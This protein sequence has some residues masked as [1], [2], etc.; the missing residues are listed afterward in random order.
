MKKLVIV[1]IFMFMIF[2]GNICFALTDADIS[3]EIKSSI[4]AIRSDIQYTVDQN[5]LT[6]AEGLKNKASSVIDYDVKIGLMEEINNLVNEIKDI[7][8]GTDLTKIAADIKMV[9]ED[10]D[11]KL[12]LPSTGGRYTYRVSIK[13]ADLNFEILNS[14]VRNAGKVTLPTLKKAT[15][16]S[17]EVKIYDKSNNLKK[18]VTGNYS[19]SDTTVPK[20]STI[21][22]LKG[23][24][25][26]E[27]T[28]NY[29]MAD[30]PYIYIIGTEQEVS[31]S[32][33]KIKS[34]PETIKIQVQDYI[35]N[36]TYPVSIN[37]TKDNK[38]YSGQP[39]AN[40]LKQIDNQNEADVKTNKKFNNIIIGQYGKEINYEATFE[41]YFD[42]IFEDYQTKNLEL[43]SCS[44]GYDKTKKKIVLNKQGLFEIVFRD[45]VKDKRAYVYIAVG[46]ENGKL[47]TRYS[48]IINNMPYYTTKNTITPKS[49]IDFVKEYGYAE[50][51]IKDTFVVAIINGRVYNLSTALKIPEEGPY[52]IS[53]Y[54]IANDIAIEHQLYYKYFVTRTETLTDIRKHWAYSTIANFI[55]NNIITGYS[56]L[57]FRPD[58]N[59]TIRDFIVMMNRTSPNAKRAI[60]NPYDIGIYENDWSYYEVKNVLS[61]IP[62]DQIARAGIMQKYSYP[63]TREEVA[64]L[65]SNYYNLTDKGAKITFIDTNYST[66]LYEMQNAISN[67]LLKG[68]N[69]GT[70]RPFN[71][72]TR[73]EAV[74]IL[75]R[76][77]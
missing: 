71:L 64:F 30:K 1:F 15:K 49:Y 26:V 46:D 65:L 23:R 6:E 60:V 34:Y 16:I 4:S 43:V 27:A 10:G 24:L 73:A 35:G 63:I 39:S 42:E 45:K 40:I 59:I 50:S 76:I 47:E 33:Y 72:L 53:I 8:A 74:T 66:Y 36:K 28:D 62:Y 9:M 75:S 41:N 54:D 38:V 69:D 37:V 57:T 25:Y 18:Q 20:I 70:I 44:L 61:R 19:F 29:K 68:Y 31:S 21:Y 2:G 55:R 3:R 14:E 32:Y 11:L 52:K 58:E 7:M 5:L 12:S 48:Q 17:Y 51:D 77:K 13:N 67:G 22:V 56:D